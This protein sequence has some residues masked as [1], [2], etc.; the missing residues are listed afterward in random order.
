MCV[1][2]R[3]RVRVCEVVGYVV[4]LLDKQTTFGC[5]NYKNRHAPRCTTHDNQAPGSTVLSVEVCLAHNCSLN[6]VF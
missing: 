1:R 5:E 4:L 6:E 3:T 2:L